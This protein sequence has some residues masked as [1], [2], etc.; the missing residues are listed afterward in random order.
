MH[1]IVSSK[2]KTLPLK[3]KVKLHVTPDMHVSHDWSKRSSWHIL[4]K[5]KSS[6][7]DV[8]IPDSV[9]RLESLSSTKLVFQ[10][11]ALRVNHGVDNAISTVLL[12]SYNKQTKQQQKNKT[13]R[14]T[15][16]RDPRRRPTSHDRSQ[17]ENKGQLFQ[18]IR[19][20]VKK[21]GVWKESESEVISLMHATHLKFK[22]SAK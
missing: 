9:Q 10:S 11:P 15:H 19:T 5:Y 8:G 22:T 17:H 18:L 13:N 6:K 14:H 16:T 20:F 1:N 3:T 12:S 21:V 7:P 2:F 4:L